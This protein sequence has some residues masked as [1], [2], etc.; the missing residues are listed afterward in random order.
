MFDQ[1]HP[2]PEQI[3]KTTVT[4]I[5]FNRSF[6]RCYPPPG[7]AE[8]IKETVPKTFCFGIFRTFRCPLTAKGQSAITYF[9]SGKGHQSSS[10]RYVS[11]I[12]QHNVVATLQKQ[13][14]I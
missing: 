2:F 14:G 1:K 8:Y 12:K 9:I 5:L 6:K 10:K 7:N 11:A 4:I 13:H 3:D